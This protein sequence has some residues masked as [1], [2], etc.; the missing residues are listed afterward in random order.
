M[1]VVWRLLAPAVVY[2]LAGLHTSLVRSCFFPALGG[3]G[4][5][6]VVVHIE[7][8]ETQRNWSVWS[9]FLMVV[10]GGCSIQ[11]VHDYV[12]QTGK[13]HI[14]MVCTYYSE[15]LRDAYAMAFY[16][17]PDPKTCA[18]SPIT[19]TFGIAKTSMPTASPLQ[20]IQGGPF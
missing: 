10:M 17:I 6:G 7:M 13:S 9:F 3:G 15:G 1:G 14:E 20:S 5:A 11:P 19:A 12:L 4:G 8:G 16:G 18:R 2:W